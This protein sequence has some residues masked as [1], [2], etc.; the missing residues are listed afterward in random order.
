[1][2]NR[3]VQMLNNESLL[4]VPFRFLSVPDLS[5]QA[6]AVVFSERIY[7]THQHYPGIFLLRISKAAPP[8]LVPIKRAVVSQAVSHKVPPF[9]KKVTK[10]SVSI[11]TVPASSLQET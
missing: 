2:L 1:M 3:I 4:T 11:S 7:L 8:A 10:V 9:K 5:A 6:A